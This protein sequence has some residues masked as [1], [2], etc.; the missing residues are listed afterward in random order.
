MLLHNIKTSWRNLLKY[1]VQNIISILC[2]AVGVVCFTITFQFLR[3]IA[4]EIYTTECDSFKARLFFDDKSDNNSTCET[5]KGSFVQ[6]IM[7]AGLP[8]IKEVLYCM[9]T[10]GMN[11]TFNDSILPKKLLCSIHACS[12]LY[13]N[14][15]LYYSDITGERIGKLRE[16]EVLISDE[17]RDIVYGKDAD[18]RGSSINDTMVIS[19]V[20]NTSSRM[21][22]NINGK[23]IFRC[24]TQIGEAA[25]G[26][27][28][29]YQ[30]TVLLNEGYSAQD[31]QRQ[32]QGFA[33]QY[34]CECYGSGF[35]LGDHIA[36]LLIMLIL[37]LIGA[38][39][40][41][42][43]VSGFLKM[44]VQ[45]FSL[46]SREMALR[47]TM[48]AKPR[49]L[50]GMLGIEIVIVFVFTLV[51]AQF[52][53]VALA[54]YAL[55]LCMQMAQDVTLDTD[56]I[57]RHIMWIT[58]ITMLFTIVSAIITVHRQLKGPVGMR[59]GK[60][61]HPRR[62]R[63]SIGLC[64]QLIVGM[65]LTF[66]MLGAFYAINRLDKMDKG[67]IEVDTE[68]YKNTMLI[69]FF[70][71]DRIPDF[72]KLMNARNDL[73]EVSYMT[74]MHDESNTVD[75]SLYYNYGEYT[76]NG[77]T[78]YYYSYF[79]S[80]EKIFEQLGV[81][82]FPERPA[83]DETR[84]RMCAIYVRSEEEKHYIEKWELQPCPD[85]Q[86][87]KLYLNREY[88]LIGYAPVPNEYK[89]NMYRGSYWAI[90]N[91]GEV[92]NNYFNCHGYI[93]FLIFPKPGKYSDTKEYILDI[94]SQSNPGDLNPLPIENLYDSWFRSERLFELMRE[95]C[96]IIVFVSILC[97]IASV[98]SVIAI[99]SRRREK[100][101]ALRKIHG[102]HRRD[103]I[104]LFGGY[105]IRLLCISGGIVVIVSTTVVL[106][107]NHLV[108][109]HDDPMT[110]A[111]LM[112]TAGYMLASILIV[113]MVTL[114]TIWHK[115]WVASRIEPAEIIKKD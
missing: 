49:Q 27:L 52:I 59:V 88:T 102:A 23:N 91:E 5:V 32:I 36:T 110:L 1:K 107:F 66:A 19:D 104:R 93:N 13:F 89:D 21:G 11:M 2:L 17:V 68:P 63:Q 53:A 6:S 24:T 64:V 10:F 84:S 16:G 94:Y 111:D 86:T 18:P 108:M 30:V 81:K 85:R 101:V 15:N 71:I 40:L 75:E 70:N 37:M 58:A 76:Y 74:I 112:V 90:E 98:Y 60:S 29:F 69:D 4:I 12:P 95:L 115:I 34:D 3:G 73:A 77:E 78:T 67:T 45:L 41:V 43:G 61:T 57:E 72:R 20:V 100:E 8:A 114:L 25:D 51:A 92:D 7:D 44:Q 47:R 50:I 48:G 14:N 28:H 97:I 39:V 99:E 54:S 106:L 105:Y 56:M 87:R 79:Y 82:I 83:D 109:G 22:T 33:Q 55:P 9:P 80:D 46:R 35:F 31:L 96:F 62:S 42:I 103:I 38:S 26:L 65:L 113:S